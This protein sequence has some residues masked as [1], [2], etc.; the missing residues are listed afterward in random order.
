MLALSQGCPF[1]LAA[2]DDLLSPSQT[3]STLHF[4]PQFIDGPM[5]VPEQLALGLNYPTVIPAV[6][7]VTAWQSIVPASLESGR[8]SELTM[9]ALQSLL[10]PLLWYA[11]GKSI[12]TGFLGT[13]RPTARSV[14]L[15]LRA[16]QLVL[17]TPSLLLIIVV[18][19]PGSSAAPL[20]TLL[21]LVW[22]SL[23]TTTIHMVLARLA[24]STAPAR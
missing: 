10:I 14:R 5:S 17:C 2:A 1:I 6:L 8:D 22:F 3:D 19:A 16:L 24:P 9:H 23:T 13:Y 12:D 11:I 18:V 4:H 20:L 21:A 15:T 7:L